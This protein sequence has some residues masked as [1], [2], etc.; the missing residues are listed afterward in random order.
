MIDTPYKSA[1]VIVHP[2][3]ARIHGYN[4]DGMYGDYGK[5]EGRLG[6]YLLRL[7]PKR[8][9]IVVL[10]ESVLAGRKFKL[11]EKLTKVH[12]LVTADD[13]SYFVSTTADGMPQRL[14]VVYNHLR[15]L[16]VEVA[17]FVGEFAWWTERLGCLAGVARDFKHRGFKIRGVKGC[18][19]PDNPPK[20]WD[21]PILAELYGMQT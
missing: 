9:L 18:V 3:G 20:N 8:P 12:T 5:Y 16:G 2:F 10:E 11:P 14:D 7:N 17:E 21:D 15:E 13:S 19:F 4:P 1:V 6:R